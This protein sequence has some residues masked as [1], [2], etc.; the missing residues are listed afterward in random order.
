ML[1]LREEGEIIQDVR[2]ISL[3][4][5]KTCI[6]FWFLEREREKSSE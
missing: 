5:I 3:E 2:K 4:W 1:A 6:S